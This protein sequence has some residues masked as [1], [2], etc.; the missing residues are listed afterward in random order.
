M[1]Q[2]QCSKPDSH[3]ITYCPQQQHAGMFI[4]GFDWTLY[5]TGTFRKLPTVH[6][7]TIAL[8]RFARQLSDS[9]QFRKKELAY[10]AALEDQTPGLG[11][12]PVRRHW[13]FL[14]ACPD[15]PYLL[16][17]GQQLWQAH[18]WLRAQRYDRERFAGYYINKLIIDG[19]MSYERNLDTLQYTG[20]DDL[21]EACKNNPYVAD[22]LKGKTVGQYL[23]MR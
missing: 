12:Q 14:L 8:D 2:S 11:A 16:S 21:I 15:N 18:G 9:L 23:V 3:L 7:A 4:S 22:R 20:P 5:G 13:H 10:Y 6:D 17:C 19:A 1:I